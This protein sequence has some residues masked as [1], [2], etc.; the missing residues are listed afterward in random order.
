M[1]CRVCR[2]RPS[3]HAEVRTPVISQTSVDFLVT[4]QTAYPSRTSARPVKFAGL[5]ADGVA[6]MRLPCAAV[7][8]AV[9]RTRM[10]GFAVMIDA[11]V[12]RFA[13]GVQAV[14]GL[15]LGRRVPGG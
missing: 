3:A 15:W 7:E 6:L 4:A 2:P 10:A 8:Q 1:P 13:F 12:E 14:R 5:T 9:Q 11:W